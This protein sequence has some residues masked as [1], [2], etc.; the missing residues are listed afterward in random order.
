MKQR[1]QRSNSGHNAEETD[2]GVCDDNEEYGD[3]W[4]ANTTELEEDEASDEVADDVVLDEESD[5]FTIEE[6]VAN[7]FSKWAAGA[8]T[9]G[10]TFYD[11]DNE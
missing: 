5:E 11:Y 1:Q 3:E 7:D 2:S 8:R 6:E 4:Y 9:R 10:V